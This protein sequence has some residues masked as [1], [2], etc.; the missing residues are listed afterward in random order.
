MWKAVRLHL[1]GFVRLRDNTGRDICGPSGQRDQGVDV[2]DLLVGNHFG[3]DG[4]QRINHVLV[5]VCRTTQGVCLG[6]GFCC[7]VCTT[8]YHRDTSYFQVHHARFLDVA[9]DFPCTVAYP[10]I[11]RRS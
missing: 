11:C 4:F 5:E 1:A 3:F 2:V 9:Q 10:G 6:T 7:A 8:L